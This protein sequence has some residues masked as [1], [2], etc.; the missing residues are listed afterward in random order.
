MSDAVPP[1]RLLLAFDFYGAGNLGDDLMMDGLRRAATLLAHPPTLVSACAW[2][3]AS[4][5]RRIP[6]VRWLE[7]A[8]FDAL[9]PEAG[10]V[11]VGA[12]GTP[13]QMTSGDW[14]LRWLEARTQNMAA[15]RA[16]VLL[17]V[18][19]EDEIEGQAERFGAI[20]SRF[21]RIS[22]RDEHGAGLVRSLGIDAERVFAG[23]DLADVSLAPLTSAP[24]QRPAFDLGLVPV[25]EGR[26]E[27]LP[28]TLASAIAAFDGS[29]AFIAGDVRGL[30]GFESDVAWRAR[31][32]DAP[33][34]TPAYAAG[35]MRDLLV[36][37][38][39]CERVVSWRYH[40]LLTGAWLG[41][42]VAAVARSSKVRAL[43]EDLGVP[44]RPSPVS[45]EDMR[46]LARDA[47]TVA[48][49]RLEARRQRAIEAVSWTL[50]I[51]L[52][53]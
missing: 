53:S 8:A 30:S 32:D 1:A 24:R 31:A 46:S 38:A 23:A 29:A 27:H 43:A 50:G 25:N 51:D 34:L 22:T 33:L 13:F 9:A 49:D 12:G 6:S 42:R 19:A 41:R 15:A 17:C 47:C 40:G 45:A 3:I 7:P 37:F 28:E 14:F 16:R 4:Q 10:D 48:R 39:L 18:G 44:W 52:R 11:W 21:D 2:D 36:P 20:A 5:R 35:S 26:D